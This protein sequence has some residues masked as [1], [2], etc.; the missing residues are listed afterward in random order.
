[1]TLPRLLFTQPIR[2]PRI[3]RGLLWG[4]ALGLAVLPAAAEKDPAQKELTQPWTV[5]DVV[6]QER[7]GPVSLARDG[8][9]VV[10][11]A[12]HV[13]AD[14]DEPGRQDRL[15]LTDLAQAAPKAEDLSDSAIALTHGHER[16]SAVALSPDG[17]RLAFITNRKV[18]GYD[19]EDG[20][21]QIWILP[22]GGGEA[23]TL[24]SGEQGVQDLR[25][26]DDE[27]LLFLRSED[28]S[29]RNQENAQTQDEAVAVDDVLDHPPERLFRVDLDGEVR[30]L[31][32]H[33]DWVSEMEV[34]PDGSQAVISASQSTRFQFDAKIPPKTFLVDLETGERREILGDSGLLP[35]SFAWA[36]D[37]TFYFIDDFSNHPIYRQATVA[38]LYRYDL[39]QNEARRVEHGHARGIGAGYGT[40]PGG[41]VTLLAD[42]ARYTAAHINAD[43]GLKVL[44]TPAG[45]GE[46]LDRLEA[47]ADGTRVV[48][49]RSTAEESPQ[50]YAAELGKAGWTAASR[51][52]HLNESHARRPTGKTEIVRWTGAEGDEVEGVL[53]YPF[54]WE[55]GKTYPLILDI[56]GGPTGYDRHSWDT[57]WASPTPLWRQRGAFVFRVNY[58]GS[59]NY[60]LEWA[61]S[62]RERYY[63]L[64]IPDIESGVDMLIERGLVDPEQLATTGWSNGGILSAGLIVHTDRYKA[65]IVGAADVEWI[66]DWGNV[67]FGAAFDNYYFGG[68]PWKRLEHYIEKSPFFSVEKVT[69]PTL[70]HTGT[71][72]RAVPPHQSWSMFRAMQFVE[73]TD[74]RLVLYPG[75]PHG[76]RSIAHQKRKV[77]EDVAWID[78]HLFGRADG[79]DPVPRHSALAARL[80]LQDAA[81]QGGAFGLEVDGVLVPET[82]AYAGLEVSRFEVTVAQWRAFRP[83][84]FADLDE[85]LP[86]FGIDFEA[87][88]D[89][90]QW[91]SKKTGRTFDL[92][93][94]DEAGRLRGAA[95][96]GDGAAGNT[97]EGW[98]GAAPNPDDR[99]AILKEVAAK[100]AHL[101]KSVGGSDSQVAFGGDKTV[102]IYD[103]GG[104]V[105]EWAR[106]E[107]DEEGGRA[108]GGSADRVAGSHTEP[109]PAYIGLR[110]LVRGTETE[111]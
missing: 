14:G 65:A 28:T 107:G 38:H 25:W 21:S 35:R 76:L 93:T 77:R 23:E 42:G 75:E 45:H 87:A 44:E 8:S 12:S 82:V 108:V 47:S 99:V 68:P 98:I 2:R 85:N 70:L 61:E 73:K 50:L 58:H 84:A 37:D 34:S 92:P 103:L 67:D 11:V 18:P 29:L 57:N 48:Y 64:E 15:Y 10:W 81:S 6:E 19:G 109:E 104:N 101:L 60:G 72:D 100:K 41:V 30:R 32:R 96:G 46:H 110:V 20:G 83:D 71:E 102:R 69:T 52:T 55:E 66:S 7:L 26:I 39:G 111:R 54:G 53:S 59:G 16:I 9:V 105:A 51:L 33:A 62:I 74:T 63:E 43:G 86:A 36:D 49:V 90:V 31:G 13:E 27:N 106:K 89:Y 94:V 97:L 95:G 78:R 80:G 17:E 79:V 56:H 1:M 88:E 24:T 91:L 4:L 22:I 40:V 3:R 5:D